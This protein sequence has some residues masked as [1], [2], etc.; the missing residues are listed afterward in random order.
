MKCLALTPPVR[1]SGQCWGSIFSS[2]PSTKFCQPIVPEYQVDAIFPKLHNRQVVLGAA[3]SRQVK[4][5]EPGDHLYKRLSW[6]G[7]PNLDAILV[8]QKWVDEG[9][10]IGKWKLQAYVK[11]LRKY[12]RYR[13]ALQ[14]SEWI[15]SRPDYQLAPADCAIRLDLIAKVHGIQSA[16][17]YFE[18]LP[19]VA[20]NKLTYGSLL[21]V[22]AREKLAGKA[23]AVMETIER[24]GYDISTLD[25]NVM[26]NLYMNTCQFEKVQ[27]MF[28]KMRE[29]GVLPDAYSYNIW[30]TTCATM[31]DLDKMEQVMDEVKRDNNVNKNWTIYS[32]LATMYMKAGLIDK[33]ETALDELKRK[34]RQKD[35]SAHEFLISLYASIG[36]K[37]EVYRSWQSLKSAFPR[38]LN[39][40]Y[41]FILSSLVKIGDTKGAEDIFK[42]W[43]SVCVRYDI[44]IANILISVYVRQNLLENAELLIERISQRGGKPNCNSWEMLAEI[45]IQNGM[46]EKAVIAMKNIASVGTFIQWQPKPENVLA[47][48]THFEKHGDIEGAKNIFE[49]IKD[50]N[51]V[52]TEM[53]NSFL[54]TFIE[55]GKTDI[56]IL[57]QMRK[58]VSPNEETEM[59]LRQ[60]CKS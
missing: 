51:C 32:T 59:L 18:G 10:K 3:R 49:I 13:H 37:E 15:S 27:L 38:V 4:T 25:Y 44:R 22:Y 29:S 12:G 46:F 26:M 9:R 31:S 45:Y 20:K 16:E 30:I 14:V 40:S 56:E 17:N 41:I 60:V 21:N 28:Q 36:N 57:E 19:D 33:A 34:M 52:N 58:T 42:E 35:R 53:Y 50:I 23:E 7:D 48:L 47:I 8:L 43:E 24:S 2:K 39:R 6:L 11:S 5:L 55:A 54:R 1:W